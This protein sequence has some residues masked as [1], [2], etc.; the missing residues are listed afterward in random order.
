MI[1]RPALEKPA[2]TGFWPEKNVP[3]PLGGRSAFFDLCRFYHYQPGSIGNIPGWD[4]GNTPTVCIPMG[5][6]YF[7]LIDAFE[8]LALLVLDRLRCFFCR[9]NIMKLKRFISHDL[10]GWPR[11]DANYILITEI[12]LMTLFLTMNA[13]DALLTEAITG[14]CFKQTGN[15]R[16]FPHG[17]IHC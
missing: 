15:F 11:S 10:D 1:N 2:A 4:T 9:S 6:L 17:C 14:I 7:W 12:I 3:E 16:Y 5:E 13:S 8:I